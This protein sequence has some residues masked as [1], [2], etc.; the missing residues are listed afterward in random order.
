MPIQPLLVKPVPDS[1]YFWL[2]VV[3]FHASVFYFE[4]ILSKYLDIII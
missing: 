4:N 1:E 2:F 3:V